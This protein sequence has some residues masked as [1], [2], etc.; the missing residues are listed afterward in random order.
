MEK[1]INVNLGGRPF[2]ITEEAYNRLDDYLKS[3]SV[4]LKNNECGEEIVSD[5]EARIGELCAERLQQ[6]CTGFIDINL[7]NEMINR[8]GKPESM[9][10]EE[11]PLQQNS[12]A[13]EEKET[14]QENN[15]KKIFDKIEFDKKYYLDEDD[16]MIG[17][18]F[19]GLAAYLNTDVTILRIIG[20]ILIGIS[21][22]IGLISYLV[23]WI[24]SPVAHST[25]EKLIM[26]G[27]NPTPEN[28]ADKI[29]RDESRKE[30][31]NTTEKQ[32]K[33]KAKRF[34]LATTIV[35]AMLF[36]GPQI[37]VSGSPAAFLLG[38]CLIATYTIATIFLALKLSGNL[39]DKTKK[40]LTILLVTSIG[41]TLISC[42][43]FTLV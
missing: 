24:I 11:E 32:K 42:C 23:V 8:M 1:T 13:H 26:Q 20:V 41:I 36:L 35:A 43:Y 10:E 15:F 28:I 16:R 39:N 31:E 21:G 18:V 29:T 38:A 22:L 3:I 40:T 6:S 19:S 14:K 2:Q 7:V 12:S 37:R 25:T 5:I 17:G 9:I 30:Q 4:S 33:E 27:L 34:L